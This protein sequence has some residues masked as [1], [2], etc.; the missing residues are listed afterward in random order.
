MNASR[1]LALAALCLV[2]TAAQAAATIEGFRAGP[3]VSGP[4]FD[5][6]DLKGRVVLVE[7]WGVNCPPCRASIPH[8][9]E[10]QAKYG[11]DQF[12]I[13][14]NHCQDADE[15]K[16]ASVFKSCGGSDLI[17]VVNHGDLP[18][19]NVS[20]IP[21]C[22]LFSHE[23][24]LLYEGSPFSLDAPVESAV[25]NSP[26]FLIA[27][28]TYQK[29]QKHAAAIGALRS[30]LGGT[31]KSLRTLAKG[32]DATAKEEADH[33]LGKVTEYSERNLEKITKDRSEDPVAASTTL[34]RMVQLL[35]GD[36][37]GAPYEALVKELKAD[38]AFQ[39][40]LK[41]AGMLSEVVAQASKVGLDKNPEDAK[42][43]RQA[44]TQIVEGL[45]AV[46]KKFPDTKAAAQATDL[47]KRW[48]I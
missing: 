48:N 15:A 38:K 22:F 24:K 41:A 5:A 34:A 12:V 40:E 47:A 43:N 19:A 11:R 28:R 17:T 16:A 44:M 39:A 33:L 8:L 35:G 9:S 42:R 20:G 31:L 36:E 7:Y 18:G 21:H 25:K 6:A 26:G 37:L 23:G 32:D 13:V 29:T 4:K 2:A 30:N 3:H 45:K 1:L 27:G 46:V 10:L 14:A